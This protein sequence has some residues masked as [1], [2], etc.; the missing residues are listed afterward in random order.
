MHA[1]GITHELDTGPSDP[2]QHW[3]RLNCSR[4]RGSVLL[5]EILSSESG[6]WRDKEAEGTRSGRRREGTPGLSGE[7]RTE[8]GDTGG[9][10]GEGRQKVLQRLN[11]KT[12]EQI[13]RKIKPD[14]VRRCWPANR[15]RES[16]PRKKTRGEL[17]PG[18]DVGWIGGN[19]ETTDGRIRTTQ[20]GREQRE[21]TLVPRWW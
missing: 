16:R 10:D 15:A 5:P 4:I 13:E 9:E 6:R 21:R 12:E 1:C 18:E 20:M 7:A 19:R 11:E 2:R 3:F 8:R 14:S 17:R